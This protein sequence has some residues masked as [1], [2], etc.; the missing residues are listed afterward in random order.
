MRPLTVLRLSIFASLGLTTACSRR[1][2]AAAQVPDAA[3]ADLPATAPQPTAI[4]SAELA[5][6]DQA[7]R[8]SR[9][10]AL[11]LVAGPGDH[12]HRPAAAT[13]SAAIPGKACPSGGT[14]ECSRSSQCTDGK[15]GQCLEAPELEQGRSA[16]AL[17]MQM[18]AAFGSG[19]GAVPVLVPNDSGV[20]PVCSCSYSCATD[21]DCKKD[22]ACVC[23][24][25][26]GHSECVAAFCKTD[27]DCKGTPC[28]LS[29]WFNGCGTSRVLACRTAKDTCGTPSDCPAGFRG[30]A[31]AYSREDSRWACRTENCAIGRPFTIDGDARHAQRAER[32]DWRREPVTVERDDARAAR[33]T[34]IACMEHASIASFARFTLELLALGAP[35]ELVRDAQLAALD[36][37]EHA[38]LAFELASAHAGRAIGPGPLD[39]RGVTV[40]DDVEEIARSLVEE[41]C[42]GETIGA[43]EA[44]RDAIAEPGPVGEILSRI[45]R[46]E[47]RHAVLAWRTLQW[48][49]EAHPRATRAGMHEGLRAAYERYGAD[50]FRREVLDGIVTPCARALR[51]LQSSE[52]AGVVVDDW[53]LPA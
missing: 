17:Q 22:E 37:I 32:S 35:A 11:G 46:D 14:G 21:A 43:A 30:G 39:V 13:C 24:G 2:P 52:D 51:A 41:G 48:M 44:A 23:T 29:E 38:R 16:D 15:N 25:E 4:S 12:L 53:Y 45:A 3:P 27:A 7:R 50:E 26:H 1:E 33:W 34:E 20:V 8:E 28:E 36:E 42:V 18:L 9:A 31:C 10:A 47:E 49:L 40:R 19:D 5:R 6:R